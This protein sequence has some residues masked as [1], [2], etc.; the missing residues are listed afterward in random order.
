MATAAAVPAQHLPRTVPGLAPKLGV[1]SVGAGSNSSCAVTA[2]GRARCWGAGFTGQLGTGSFNN[3][4][5]PATVSGDGGLRTAGQLSV[6]DSF[7]CST[8]LQ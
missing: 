4:L 8:D 3:E 1:F 7:A 2:D 6:G 5:L